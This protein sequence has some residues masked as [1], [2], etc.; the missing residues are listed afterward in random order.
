MDRKESLIM[1]KTIRDFDVTNKTVIIRCDFNVPMKEGEITDDTRIKA[2]LET[3]EYALDHQAKVVL[4]SHL[5]RVK[6]EE[7]KQKNT[8]EPVALRLSEYLNQEVIFCEETHGDLLKETVEGLSSGEVLLM[9]NTRFEDLD[10]KKESGNDPEL[11]A[12]WSSLGDIFINDA[13]GTAH[14]AHASNVGIASHL[15]SGVGFLI[16]KELNVMGESL[17]HPKSPF[18]VIL[19]GSKVSDKIGVIENLVHKVDHLLIGGGMAFSFLKASG[20]EVGG[21]LVDMDHLDFCKKML[22]EHQDKLILP[23][24][25][26]VGKELSEATPS[27]TCF[28]NEIKNDEMGL[29]IGPKTVK[30]FGQYLEDSKTIIWN[31]PVG[32][33]EI[34]KFSEGTKGLCEI[35]S[36]LDAISIIGGG[37][38]AAAVTTFG[39]KDAMTHISTGGGA[40]L[41]LLEGKTLPGIACIDEK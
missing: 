13:F 1:K 25:V 22:E 30:L 10:G 38:T 40:S 29:D 27:R 2:S 28:I 9:E 36:K 18:V 14:R 23:I 32:V 41:E 4:M 31:G 15:P 33:F 7:D 5:G 3:I 17:E 20:I 11:G 8:L 35:I 26:V 6:T 12:F 24:D 34:E 21:S 19:G 39:Y 16:E 37:D